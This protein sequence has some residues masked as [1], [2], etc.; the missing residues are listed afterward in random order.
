[1]RSSRY[2]ERG[3]S[4]T[5]AVD[6][7]DATCAMLAARAAAPERLINGQPTLKVLPAEAWINRS[8]TDEAAA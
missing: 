4:T 6:G 2:C 3:I 5:S 1:M 8:A 7:S